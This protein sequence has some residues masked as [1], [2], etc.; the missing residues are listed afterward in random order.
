MAAHLPIARPDGR[1]TRLPRGRRIAAALVGA[2]ASVGLV[3]GAAAPA[4]AQSAQPGSTSSVS[5]PNTEYGPLPVP[6]DF[7]AGVVASLNPEVPPP[8]ANDFHCKPTAENPRP[9]VMVNPT[10]TT[11]A[12]AWQA[13]APFLKNDGFCVFTFNHGNITPFPGMPLQA[14]GDIRQAGQ[15]LSA[16]VDRVLAETGATEVDLVGHSQGGGVLPDYYLKV[17]GGAD[18]V[19]TKV[20]ISPSTQTTLS[21]LVYLRTLIPRLGPAVYGSLENTAPALTQQAQG[22]DLARE[23]YPEGAVGIPGVQLYSVYS[24]YDEA[25]TPF[26][27]QIYSGEG[28]TNIHLQDGCAEDLSEHIATMYSERTWLHVRNALAPNRAEPVPCFPVAP[29]WPGVH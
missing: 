18:K 11:Q 4:A 26:T 22:S 1:V 5:P 28:V 3:L 10:F 6:F 27:R 7:R 29:F 8:G 15:T 19:H 17:L 2:A 14:L 16:F 21:E 24:E 12:F 25:V 23:V 13:G 20:G 9:V